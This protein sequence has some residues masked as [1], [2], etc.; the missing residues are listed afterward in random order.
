MKLIVK[1]ESILLDYLIEELNMPKKRIK[2][3]LTHG[4]IYVNNNKT[5]KYDTKLHPGMIIVDK[6]EN[7]I[8]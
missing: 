2:Q 5:T 6:Y 3:Y 4:S 8:S 7:C 1:K